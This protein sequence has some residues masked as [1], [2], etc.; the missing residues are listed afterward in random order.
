MGTAPP[1]AAALLTQPEVAALLR[2]HVETVRRACRRGDLPIVR[3][4]QRVLVLRAPVERL[5]LEGG[6]IG[7]PTS[8]VR[9]EDADGGRV[10]S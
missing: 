3:V 7:E 5:L 10:A 9:S 8:A 4:G 2:V 6:V 1:V